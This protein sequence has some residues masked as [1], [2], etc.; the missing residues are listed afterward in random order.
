MYLQGRRPVPDPDWPDTASGGADWVHTGTVGPDCAHTG[1]EQ[2]VASVANSTTVVTV[3][4]VVAVWMEAGRG[5]DGS[6]RR[7]LLVGHTWR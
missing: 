5:D 3:V 4:T 7:R 1:Q 2:T 6:G